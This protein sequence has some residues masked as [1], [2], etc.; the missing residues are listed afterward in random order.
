MSKPAYRVTLHLK[1]DDPTAL[2]RHAQA[3]ALREGGDPAAM[4]ADGAPKI[5]D[6][7]VMVLDPGSLP[8][9]LITSSRAELTDP[10]HLAELLGS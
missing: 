6:C 5:E 3:Q 9:C 2:L 10:G 7:L 8:G 4:L 1:V